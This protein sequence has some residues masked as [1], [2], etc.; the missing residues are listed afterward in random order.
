MVMGGAARTWTTVRDA[1]T[2]TYARARARAY[3]RAA[4][5]LS[6]FVSFTAAR[7]NNAGRNKVGP[8]VVVA[9]V[10]FVVVVIVVIFLP[11]RSGPM[12]NAAKVLGTHVCALA[13][14]DCAPTLL[15]R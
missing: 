1:R 14:F 5:R 11:V 10:R 7:T 12:F 9:I 15:D 3:V 8:A 6:R 4:K 13:A 2:H